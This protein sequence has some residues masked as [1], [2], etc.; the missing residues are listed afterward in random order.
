[1]NIAT[2]SR[3]SRLCAK[4]R[5]D[6]RRRPTK[7]E[8]LVRAALDGMGVRYIFQK[9]YLCNGYG[10]RIVDFYL[11]KPMRVA[12]EIDGDSHQG[13]KEQDRFREWQIRTASSAKKIRFVRISDREVFNAIDLKQFLRVRLSRTSQIYLAT[14]KSDQNQG[15]VEVIIG[16]P[17]G[18]VGQGDNAERQTRK[19]GESATGDIVKSNPAGLSPLPSKTTVRLNVRTPV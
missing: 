8:S 9:G 15:P 19:P 10:V 12:L 4:R 11:P 7:A 3:L 17:R 2:H 16:T 5:E 18:I 6:L 1:V 13:Q 14:L